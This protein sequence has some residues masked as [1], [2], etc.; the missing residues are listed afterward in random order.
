MSAIAAHKIAEHLSVNPTWLVMG[1]GTPHGRHVPREFSKQ[2][3]SLARQIDRLSKPERDVI[4][5]IVSVM[6]P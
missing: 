6:L 1:Q 5:Q 3:R 2:T 4:Q